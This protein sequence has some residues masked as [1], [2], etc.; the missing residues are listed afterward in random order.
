MAGLTSLCGFVFRH[1]QLLP[2]HMV[3][4][5]WGAGNLG[6]CTSSGCVLRE[7]LHFLSNTTC[8]Q[9]GPSV[10]QIEGGME[11]GEALQP[12]LHPWQ[13]RELVLH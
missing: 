9:H 13:A 11:L 1:A 8:T 7:V 12:H 6:F 3:G 10:P 5:E 2:A 4:E